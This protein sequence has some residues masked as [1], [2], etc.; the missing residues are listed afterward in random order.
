MPVSPKRIWALLDERQ[1]NTNQT[2]GVAEALGVPFEIKKIVF[3]ELTRL[4]N[5]ISNRTT[6]GMS[7][8]SAAQLAAPWPDITITTARRLGLVAS[9]IKWK[10]PSTFIA[11]IQWPGW[12]ASHFDLIAAPVHDNVR[13]ANN[14]FTTVGAPHRVTK[15]IIIQDANVWRSTVSHLTAPRIA[16]LVG[17]NAGS[18]TFTLQHAKTLAIYASNMV[19][20][21]H[22]SLLMTTSRRT[23][24]EAT[25]VLLKC[26]TASNYFHVW[27]DKSPTKNNP[28]YGFLGLADAIIATGDSISMCSEACATGKPVFIFSSPEFVS[29][30]HQMFIDELYKRGLARP[31]VE[32]GN[33]IFTPTAPLNDSLDVA[34]EI[35]KRCNF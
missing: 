6:I 18:Y 4:P 13:P 17:G 29:P 11:Q 22:G 2:L 5:F 34:S 32:N 1:G 14:V 12:P 23:G 26:T 8:E 21:L 19:Q 9:Y 25:N 30:K 24:D 35:K 31:L 33:V 15:D 20:S 28:F 7:K 27:N 16:V 3:N 10:N